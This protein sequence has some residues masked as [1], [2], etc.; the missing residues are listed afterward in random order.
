MAIDGDIKFS[1]FPGSCQIERSK[2]RTLFN[3]FSF[4]TERPGDPRDTRIRSRHSHKPITVT[5]GIDKAAP[6]VWS[7]LCRGRKIDEVEIRLWHNNVEGVQINY[8]TFTLTNARIVG[9][10]FTQLHNLKS[11]GAE[12]ATEA[13][14][15]YSIA[16]ESI[17][18]TY[19][20]GS[21]A[22]EAE[23][24]WIKSRA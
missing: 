1:S 22:V 23:D 11:N 17:V 20:D 14:V 10:E 3:A 2:D 15:E 6:E 9:C 12:M 24:S 19:D 4:L 8:T 5:C 16:F 18:V 7:H 21:G 13:M